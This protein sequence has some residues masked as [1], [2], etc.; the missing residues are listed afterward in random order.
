M[1]RIGPSL[2][3]NPAYPND[4]ERTVVVCDD[5]QQAREMLALWDLTKRGQEVIIKDKDMRDAVRDRLGLG[6]QD[7]VF[8]RYSDGFHPRTYLG[9]EVDREGDGDMTGYVLVKG[10]GGTMWVKPA[11]RTS[12]ANGLRITEALD[13]AKHKMQE[14]IK[15]AKASFEGLRDSLAPWKDRETK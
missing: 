13:Q 4:A 3:R 9:A 6:L 15:Q 2:A 12:L 7:Y 11:F 8:W 1:A 14:R 10:W 5:E